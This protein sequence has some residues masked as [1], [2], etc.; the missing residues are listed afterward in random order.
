MRFSSR[1]F[2]GLLASS[3][4]LTGCVRRYQPPKPNE[5]HAIVKLRRVYES[6]AGVALQETATIGKEIV[7]SRESPAA[8][9]L[10]PEVDA[11]L[12]HPEPADI[13]LS[14]AFFHPESRMVRE[15][16][17]ESVPHQE[18]ERYNCGSYKERRTCSRSV[19]RYRQ[20]T[21]YRWVHKTERVVDAACGRALSIWPTEG[22]TYLFQYTYQQNGA[23]HMSCFEQVPTPGG[24]FENH[25]CQ[26]APPP[27]E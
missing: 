1:L 10:I 15:S 14:S 4:L 12:V 21:R 25:P 7:L 8:E 13:A 20:E 6:H 23:C 9:A 5:P 2:L 27:A 18:S 26:Y 3:F 22:R 16:Y 17:T 11:I 19:T 24:Q